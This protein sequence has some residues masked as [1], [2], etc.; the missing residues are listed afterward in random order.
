MRARHENL[1]PARLAAHV[2]DVGAHAVAVAEGFAG[3]QVLAANYRLGPAQVDGEPAVLGALDQ[4]VRDLLHAVLVFLVLARPLCLA[5]LLHNHLLRRLRRDA[6][7]VDGRQ[8]VG[9]VVAGLRGG[10][11][12]LRLADRD[13]GGLV[14]D[15]LGDL[16]IAHQL[17]LAGLAV[18]IGAD[19]VLL[20]VLPLAGV[21]DRLLHGLEHELTLDALLPGDGIGDLEQFEAGEAR[22]VLI[23]HHTRSAA[24]LAASS[25]SVSTSF[26]A[27]IPS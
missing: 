6:A 16:E 20:T 4:A 8:R 26:A 24:W 15:L 19:I 13:L 27:R 10:V 12:L 22:G 11:A 3:Q 14:L 9:Q 18:D 25:S 17:D 7:E 23:R 1:R 21:G 2:V 5:H